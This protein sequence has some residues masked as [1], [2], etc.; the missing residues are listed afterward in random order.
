MARIRTI[1]PE[2]WKDEELSALPEITHMFAAALL[3]YADDEGYFNANP[4]L[5]KAELFPLREPSRNIHGMLSELSNIGYIKLYAGPKGK[6]FGHVV[7]FEVHQKVN[8]PSASKIKGLIDFTESSLNP[9]EHLTAGKEQG[10]GKGREGKGSL[11]GKPDGAA[12]HDDQQPEPKKT[13]APKDD[14]PERVID[15]LNQKTGRSFEH[16]DG[17]L[18][19]IRARIAEGATF[20]KL[21]A[22]IDMKCAEWLN[23]PKMH[24]YL[25][26]ATLFNAEKFNQYVGLIGAPRPRTPEEELDEAFGLSPGNATHGG[27]DDFLDGVWQEVTGGRI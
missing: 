7:N 23:N 19:F 25:R 24:E 20:E 16:V 5:I 26:P 4:A 1:K 6:T 21:V 2:F 27:E 17:N 12:D 10:T 18:K 14:T 13:P 9:H 15:Y 22:V 3:N 11:S 8:R